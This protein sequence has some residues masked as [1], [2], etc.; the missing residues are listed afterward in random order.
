MTESRNQ[1]RIQPVNP[2]HASEAIR[3]VF[4]QI[5]CEVRAA[6]KPLSCSCPGA[7]GF[8]RIRGSQRGAGRRSIR[9][10]DSRATRARKSPRATCVPIV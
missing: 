10:K 9:R 2:A 8:R 6:A 5:Q 7:D 1:I 4:A 3:Q